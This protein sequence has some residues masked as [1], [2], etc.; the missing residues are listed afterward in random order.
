MDGIAENIYYYYYKLVMIVTIFMIFVR[1]IHNLA[2]KQFK[3]S[4]K[5]GSPS[6]SGGWKIFE[7]LIM[8]GGDY[9]ASKKI[10]K[11]LF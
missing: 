2:S 8:V 6:K 3:N 5:G 1:E 10:C 9:S 7:K 4:I 11:K